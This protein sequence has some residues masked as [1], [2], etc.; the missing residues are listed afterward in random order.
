M[1]LIGVSFLSPR[2]IRRLALLVFV[3]S[4]IL[5]VATL[6]IHT[7]TYREAQI[8]RQATALADPGKSDREMHY[9]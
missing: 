7:G 2:Q 3:A 8:Y 9:F 6:V 1:V 5:I 4:I